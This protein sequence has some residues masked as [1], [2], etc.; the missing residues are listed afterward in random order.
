MA[1]CNPSRQGALNRRMSFQMIRD[2]YNGGPMRR[3]CCTRSLRHLLHH[4]HKLQPIKLLWSQ[5]Q[6]LPAEHRGPVI[7]FHVAEKA[8]GPDVPSTSVN[9]ALDLDCNPALQVCEVKPPTSRRT[10]LVF[11][12]PAREEQSIQHREPYGFTGDDFCRSF[13]HWLDLLKRA[14]PRQRDSFENHTEQSRR[15]LYSPAVS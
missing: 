1:G 8:C 3:I 4:L 10:K 9:A 7:F 6:H 14:N 11:C 2:H 5:P 12:G 15:G 13:F